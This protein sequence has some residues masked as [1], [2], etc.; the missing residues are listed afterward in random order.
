[1]KVQPVIAILRMSSSLVPMPVLAILL[2]VCSVIQVGAAQV[3]G[4]GWTVTYVPTSCIWESNGQ[5]GHASG[6]YP[7][8]FNA[9]AV[10]VGGTNGGWPNRYGDCSCSGQITARLTW[11]NGGDKSKVP[12]PVVIVYEHSYAHWGGDSGACSSGL[13]N[14]TTYTEPEGVTKI[15]Y[16]WTVIQVAGRT[17]LPLPASCSPSASA[18]IAENSPRSAGG[19]SVW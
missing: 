3:T 16:R 4:P 19:C 13:P 14:E 11:S 10:G 17:S 8:P 9:C 2:L 18:A 1:M 6:P 15:G 7:D 12:P 5:F